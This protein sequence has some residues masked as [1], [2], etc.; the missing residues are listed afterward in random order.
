GAVFT[1]GEEVGDCQKF[2]QGL[3][4]KLQA[5]GNANCLM[6]HHVRS[7]GAEQG[8]IR[9][10]I[11]SAGD[12]EAD[13]FIVAN[14]MGSRELL[15]PLGYTPA[16]Y[17]LKGYS[18]SIPLDNEQQS[19]SSPEISV[20]DYQRRIVYARMGNQLRAAAMVDIGDETTVIR[21]DRIQA[22]KR[23]ISDTFPG[24]NI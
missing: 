4:D 9:S 19:R 17:G 21:D 8:R 15:K 12:I 20:T 18:L 14:G 11:T 2:T 24:L 1:P 6:K 23:Q 22:L 3:F 7:L 16:I 10:A 5:M 13:A